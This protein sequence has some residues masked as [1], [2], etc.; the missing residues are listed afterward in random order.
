MTKAKTR[1]SAPRRTA[2]KIIDFPKT[3]RALP[4]DRNSGVAR[5]ERGG[6]RLVDDTEAGE[7]ATHEQLAAMELEPW[8]GKSEGTE[9]LT[10]ESWMNY[11]VSVIC[12]AAYE[13]R[14]PD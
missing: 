2:P 5:V 12:R 8:T 14:K 6:L 7:P 4:A 3:R 13:A 9:S 1:V 11:R 10:G